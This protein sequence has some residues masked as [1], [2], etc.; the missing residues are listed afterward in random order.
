MYN[1]IMFLNVDWQKKIDQQ[2]VMVNHLAAIDQAVEFAFDE[3]IRG[4]FV[5]VLIKYSMSL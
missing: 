2:M 5:T 1:H 3:D 4:L